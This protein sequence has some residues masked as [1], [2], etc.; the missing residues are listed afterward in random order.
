MYQ[1]QN[2]EFCIRFI[3]KSGLDTGLNPESAYPFR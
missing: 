2:M 3:S 1:P